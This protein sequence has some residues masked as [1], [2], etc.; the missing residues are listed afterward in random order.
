MLHWALAWESVR[1]GAWWAFVP[2]TLLLTLLAFALLMLQSSLDEVF[3]PRLRR[4]T[5]AT[6]RRR[7][8]RPAAV[9]LPVERP[10]PEGAAE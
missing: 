6:R 1:T 8:A 7:T 10:V 5:R 3:N 9:P 4:H 2:P